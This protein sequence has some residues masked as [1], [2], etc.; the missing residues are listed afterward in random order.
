MKTN[1]KGIIL[2]HLLILF[3]FSFSSCEKKQLENERDEIQKILNNTIWKITKVETSFDDYS[4][5]N[6]NLKFIIWDYGKEELNGHCGKVELTLN[7]GSTY[8]NYIGSVSL[9]NGKVSI[10]SFSADWEETS[11]LMHPIYHNFNT[12]MDVVI[13]SGIMTLFD[14]SKDYSIS[15]TEQ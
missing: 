1:L 13:N 2:T 5:L 9:Q 6:D 14:I 15:A 4:D 11:L 3:M 12:S 8:Y 7:D 10:I